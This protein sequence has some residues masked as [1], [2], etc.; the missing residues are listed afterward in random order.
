MAS[1]CFAI[2]TISQSSKSFHFSSI[3][4]VRNYQVHLESDADVGVFNQRNGLSASGI[5][6][7]GHFPYFLRLFPGLLQGQDHL[8]Q[9]FR[10]RRYLRSDPT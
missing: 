4:V 9:R 8:L 6:F 5:A 10:L 1:S 2:A 3:V 7:G